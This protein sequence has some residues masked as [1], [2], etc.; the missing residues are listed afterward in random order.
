MT[1]RGGAKRD[2]RSIA[3][4]GFA[5]ARSDAERR[6]VEIERVQTGVR[7]EKRILLVLKAV[8]GA[9]DLTLGETL[10]EPALTHTP[11][12]HPVPLADQ[13]DA[14]RSHRTPLSRGRHKCSPV[15]C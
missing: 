12:D 11:C 2:R 1:A 3:S 10:R 8:A 4:P 7:M 13:V 14:R 15:S 6:G 9:H 5:G